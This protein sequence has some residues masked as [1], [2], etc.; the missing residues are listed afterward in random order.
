MKN[1]W[2]WFL[3]FQSRPEQR[4]TEIFKWNKERELNK[5]AETNFTDKNL[6]HIIY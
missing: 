5:I 3:H 2:F 1:E 6:S 4:I